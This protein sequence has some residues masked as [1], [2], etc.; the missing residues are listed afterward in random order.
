MATRVII[1]GSRDFDDYDTLEVA[2]D[3]LLHKIDVECI[4][5][6]CARGADKL[7][8]TYATNR[9]YPV[10]PWPADW[11]THGKSAGYK[12]NAD[13]A[14]NADMLIAFWDGQSK[15]TKH[16][17]DLANKEGLAVFVQSPSRPGRAISRSEAPPCR[18]TFPKVLNP[19]IGR[20][21]HLA[22]ANGAC[23]WRLKSIDGDNCVMVT[24]KTGRERTAR[25]IDLRMT[26]GEQMAM[27][28]TT[29][30]NQL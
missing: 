7:G 22:W 16:M 20:L 14:A 11:D 9:G 23:V 28:E 5:S 13:M 30:S 19:V 15:G 24:P 29:P 4:L 8:E 6:G 12:R 18:D 1:S 21:Y 2:C 25:V 26:R 3:D 17:I 10:E 27:G